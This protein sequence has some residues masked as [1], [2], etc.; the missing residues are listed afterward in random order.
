[1]YAMS[2]NTATCIIIFMWPWSNGE[3]KMISL[4]SEEK[5]T[6]FFDQPNYY[7]L[8]STDRNK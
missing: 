6:I 8:V 1:M 5:N 7:L 3:R 4:K 2:S